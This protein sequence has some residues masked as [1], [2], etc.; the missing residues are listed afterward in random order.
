MSVESLFRVLQLHELRL[1]ERSPIRRTEEQ[2][3]CPVRAFQSLVGYVVPEL[4]AGREGR[5][6]LPYV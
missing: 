5:H 4:V 2:Q 1:A 6:L 3:H